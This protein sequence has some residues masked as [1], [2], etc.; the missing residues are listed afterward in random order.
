MRGQAPWQAEGGEDKR[1]GPG[2][3]SAE[4]EPGPFCY[5]PFCSRTSLTQLASGAWLYMSRGTGTWGPPMR[6]AAPPE[7]TLIEIQGSAA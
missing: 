2:W 5:G 1:R 3:S 6:V 7:V 4:S